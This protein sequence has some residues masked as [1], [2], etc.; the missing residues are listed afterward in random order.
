MSNQDHEDKINIEIEDLDG[1]TRQTPSKRS[2]RIEVDLNEEDIH[3][4]PPQTQRHRPSYDRAMLGQTAHYQEPIRRQEEKS[5]DNYGIDRDQATGRKPGQHNRNQRK[6][7]PRFDGI[8]ANINEDGFY[9]YDKAELGPR[10]LAFL[11]DSIIAFIP[12][13]AGYL[14]YMM[15]SFSS[16]SYA[17]LIIGPILLF[18]G[19]IWFWFYML[20]RDGLGKGQSYGKKVFGLM[21]VRLEDNQ[22]C[23]K[24]NSLMRNIIGICLSGI[25]LLYGA[26]HEKGQRIGDIQ[27]KTQVIQ[28]HEYNTCEEV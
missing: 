26:V 6:V 22:P 8:N 23:T 3:D 12:V 28:T 13:I 10:F 25:D 19:I 2:N 18:I 24:A 16:T 20:I 11:V 7:S 21:T 4:Y 27:L 15:M 1:E 17:G 9:E 14:F 5:R